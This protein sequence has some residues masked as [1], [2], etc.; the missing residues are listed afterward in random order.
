MENIEAYVNHRY[1]SEMIVP[2]VSITD[3]ISFFMSHGNR[4]LIT[5]DHKRCKVSECNIIHI[6]ELEGKV[7]ELYGVD[8]WAFIKRW[9]KS[10]G[11]MDSMH[12]AHIKLTLCEKQT[13]ETK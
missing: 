6:C 7:Q 9:H 4:Y 3:N 10:H 11:N 8:C 1:K 2:F 13:N 5:S 12:F